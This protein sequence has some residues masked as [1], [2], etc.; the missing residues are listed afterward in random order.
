MNGLQFC[1]KR[2]ARNS[3]QHFIGVQPQENIK[4]VANPPSAR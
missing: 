2:K 4:Q 1:I 3:I